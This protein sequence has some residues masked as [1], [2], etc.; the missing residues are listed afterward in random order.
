MGYRISKFGD[1]TVQLLNR[2]KSR[3][4]RWHTFLGYNR[5]HGSVLPRLAEELKFRSWV[6][7]SFTVYL[8]SISFVPFFHV[9]PKPGTSFFS[10]VL[11]QPSVNLELFDTWCSSLTRFFVASHIHPLLLVFLWEADHA[12]CKSWSQKS[13]SGPTLYRHKPETR[14]GTQFVS[15]DNMS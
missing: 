13:T 10:R 5:Q 15:R 9:Q 14:P 6:Y 2:S 12:G 7:T 11:C 8:M 1:D 3:E 4:T